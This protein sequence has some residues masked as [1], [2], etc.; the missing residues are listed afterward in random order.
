MGRL[1]VVSNR[2]GPLR[3]SSR[4]GGLAVGLVDALRQ[5]GGLWF[6][7]SG[8]TS[9][10]G[11]HGPLKI[12]QG[13]NV[14]LATIDLT[15]ADAYEFYTG[16]SNRTL[17]PLLHY[18]LDVAQFDRRF[19]EG[20]R[21]VNQRFAQRLKPMIGPDD[22]IWVHDYHFFRLGA[23]LRAAG[24]TNPIG[25]FLH[26]PF[27]GPEILGALPRHDGLLRSMLAYDVVGFQTERDRGS[28]VR[29]LAE[30]LD[31][32]D[33]GGTVAALGRRV[34]VRAFPIGIDATEFAQY[35]VSAE[36]NGQRRRNEKALVGRAQIIGVDRIDYS[37]GL[38]ERFRAFERLL[39][40][41]PENRN[42]VSMMQIAPP[43]RSEVDAYADM[44]RSLERLAGHINGRFADIDWTPIRFL[45]RPLPRKSLAGLYRASRVGLVTPLRDGMNLVAKEY[46]AAQ[47]PEDPGVLVLSRFAGAAETMKE[48]LIVNPFSEEGVAEAMQKAMHMP[49]DER[50]SRW[51]ALFERLVRNDAHAWAEDFLTTLAA[52]ARG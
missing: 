41:F 3:D 27:P 17:W 6:G 28:F 22:V 18:R 34:A 19:E 16:Y 48:A 5:R 9:E 37:K 42:A 21:R 44:R 23:E 15:Q 45:T 30:D 50:R 13:R 40:D 8:E 7:W 36:A 35:A 25:F 38:V 51:T 10:H 47:N 29:A 52:T 12:E 20:Y 49:L 31:V 43:S 2:V 26:V 14:R 39:E 32:R 46:V 24:V 11:T 33:E 4:A 1:I